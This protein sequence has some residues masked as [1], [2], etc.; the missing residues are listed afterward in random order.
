VVAQLG[1]LVRCGVFVVTVPGNHDEVSYHGSVYRRWAGRWP[2]VLVTNAMPGLV[3]RVDLGGVPVHLYSLAYTGGVTQVRSLAPFPR[4]ATAGLHIGAFHGSLDW[5]AGER[6]LPLLS[7]ELAAAGYDYIALGHIHRHQQ[8][9]LGAGLA[10]YPGAVE[11]KSPADPGVGHLT[12]VTLDAGR[13]TIERPE[14][15]VRRH[16]RIEVDLTTAADNGELIAA[17]RAARDPE[18]IIELVLKG[19]PAF[20]AAADELQAALREDFFHVSVR[21]ESSFVDPALIARYRGEPTVR[22]E[23]VRRL[24]ARLEACAG[25]REREVLKL[26]LLKGLA[27]LERGG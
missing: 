3:A 1:R 7:G 14:L 24:S 20:V 12:V 23:F 27:A 10:V 19:A 21:D 15:A 8:H 5:D 25:E 16:A 9:S 22:G 13:V 17:A 2:G 6:S 26:A 11:G 18:A 4:A